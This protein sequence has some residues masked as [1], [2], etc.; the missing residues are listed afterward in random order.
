MKFLLS[1]NLPPASS[2]KQNL[3]LAT[4]DWNITS[5]ERKGANWGEATQRRSENEVNSTELPCIS[6]F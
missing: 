1:R 2:T 4:K 5:R 6:A 3:K